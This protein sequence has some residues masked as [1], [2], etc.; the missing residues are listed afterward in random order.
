MR[1][2]IGNFPN[3]MSRLKIKKRKVGKKSGLKEDNDKKNYGKLLLYLYI[4]TICMCACVSCVDV[5]VR[6]PFSMSNMNNSAEVI[7]CIVSVYID[8][9]V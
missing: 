6:L 9:Y 8:V 5:C 4:C 3:N 2:K 7:T 1:E